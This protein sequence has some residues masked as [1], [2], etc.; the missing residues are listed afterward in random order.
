MTYVLGIS[1]FYHDSAASLMQDGNILAAAHEER[2]SRKKHD[3]RFPKNAI[4]YCLEE[5]EIEPS[6]LNAVIYYDNPILTFDRI[7]KSMAYAGPKS[8]DVWV[9]GAPG[10]LSA[11][12]FV[13][14][15]IRDELGD[16]KILF[17]EHHF[18][19]AAS[20][21]YPSPFEEAAILTMDGVGEWTTLAL[22]YG[23]KTGVHIQKEIKFPHSLGLLYSAFTQFCGFKVNSGEYK[24]MGLACYGEPKY[25][26]LIKK[27][28]I[29]IKHDGSFKLDMK[30]FGYLDTL[31]MIGPEFEK[32]FGGKAREPETALTQREMDI[33]ASIQKVTEEV[34]LKLSKHVKELT[35]KKNICL[36]GGVALNCVAN[37]HLVRSGLFDN[38]WIQPASGDAGGSLGAAMLA[39]FE[40]FK[41]KRPVPDPTTDSQNGSYLG[42]RFSNSEIKAYLDNNEY[43]Y[44]EVSDKQRAKLAA[45]LINDGKI[46]GYMVGRMEFGPRALG[47]RSIIGDARRP[48]T[49]KVMNLRIKY[50]E[51]FRPF[52][53]SCLVEKAKDYFDLDVPSPY[54][55]LVAQVQESRCT[56]V[57]RATSKDIHEIVNQTRSDIPAVTH[58]D[59]SARIQ[60]VDARDKPDYHEVISEFNKLTGYGVI[61]NTSFNVRGE[62]II[63][64]HLDAY[65]CF[66]RTDMDVLVMENFI[67]YKED[68]PKF[69][70]NENWRD[71]YELD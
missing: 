42:P 51:S 33:A 38:V 10:W 64:S 18:S 12:L 49:Q 16:V 5:A 22:G 56:K 53:P 69:E 36:A 46:I 9:K 48:D 20:A 70:D 21:F 4:Q 58:V 55:L 35:G 66:M 6:E 37:G 24:L 27:N 61:V 17:S 44:S 11:K 29:D 31:R 26:D 63:C 65:K 32:L 57:N 41:V 25:V 14:K 23:D 19:H 3:P 30:Y 7:I 71:E 67:L 60:T 15:L 39:M 50:R 62:P 43:K 47:A 54:M 1:A 52:A 68:Q 40:H 28:I 59:Y 8:K 13:E 34:V 2:F 45:K